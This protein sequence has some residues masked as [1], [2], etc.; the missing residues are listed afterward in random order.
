[1]L[2]LLRLLGW[3][4]ARR[5]VKAEH[6]GSVC[7]ELGSLML[8]Y[9]MHVLLDVSCIFCSFCGFNNPR[10]ELC[11]SS[12]HQE[13]RIIKSKL[14][15]VSTEQAFDRQWTG[16]GSESV[17]SNFQRTKCLHQQSQLNQRWIEFLGLGGAQRFLLRFLYEVT[18]L[19]SQV[20][21]TE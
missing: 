1:M 9:V 8:R 10:P 11:D 20:S 14:G 2:L 13:Y 3:L 15:A 16:L 7:Q 4:D 5:V 6:G 21:N 18:R 19:R 12:F 17:A